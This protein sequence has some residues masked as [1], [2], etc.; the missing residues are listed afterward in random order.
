MEQSPGGEL[1]KQVR[2]KMLEMEP[3]LGFRLRVVER[4]GRNLLT[5][6]PQTRTWSGSKCG[7]EDC[8]TC[9]QE[10]EEL[11]ECTRRSVVYESICTTCNPRATKKGEL[12]EVIKGAPSLYV[13]ESSRSVQERAGEHWGAARRGEDESHMVRHQKQVHPGAPP[14]VLFQGDKHP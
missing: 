4:T 3:I 5:S 14:P 12:E 10:G 1:A 13:G 2:N 8:I 11:P 7:R 6:F 9:N